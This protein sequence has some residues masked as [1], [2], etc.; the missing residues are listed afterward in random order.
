MRLAPSS[1]RDPATGL[2]SLASL[3]PDIVSAL[4]AGRLALW[5]GDP[6]LNRRWV[7]LAGE[8]PVTGR[9]IWAVFGDPG[10]S[11]VRVTF[12]DGPDPDTD[13]ELPGGGF[14][15]GAIDAFWAG[16]QVAARVVCAADELRALVLDEGP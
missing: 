12:R 8:H 7:V 3:D 9:P 14:V 5:A 4:L 13:P 15:A 6:H 2:P 11:G 10:G 1:L 16:P